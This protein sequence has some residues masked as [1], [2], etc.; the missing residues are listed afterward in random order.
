MLRIIAGEAKGRVLSAP[1]GRS[2]RPTTARVREALFNILGPRVIEADFLDVF[3]GSG[4]VGLEALS[5]GARRAVFI[6]NDKQALRC[7]QANLQNTGLGD[8]AEIWR[9]EVMSALAALIG[10]GESFDLIYVDPPYGKNLVSFVLPK[11]KLLSKPG[12]LVIVEVAAKGEFL[13]ETGG[14]NQIKRYVYGSTAL[15]FLTRPEGR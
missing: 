6:E 14:W 12:G 13:P 10:R 8:R 7:L 3:A 2:T 1:R 15:Y 9:S 11:L 5:R 4:A